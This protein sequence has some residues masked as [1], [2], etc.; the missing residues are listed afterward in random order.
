MVAL[1]NGLQDGLTKG[2]QILDKVFSN[3]YF[4]KITQYPLPTVKSDEAVTDITK[5]Q[6]TDEGVSTPTQ[7]SITQR[8]LIVTKEISSKVHA[9]NTLIYGVSLIAL[10]MALGTSLVIAGGMGL[11]LLGLSRM[12]QLG[13]SFDDAEKE[14]QSYI[15]AGIK[16]VEDS[17]KSEKTP[18]PVIPKK[19]TNVTNTVNTPTPKVIITA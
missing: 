5:K 16:K 10:G 14:I 1:L 7:D 17:A 13:V 19:N 9:I 15:Y 3:K 18:P 4:D 6:F 8:K 12:Y 11:G 2:Y